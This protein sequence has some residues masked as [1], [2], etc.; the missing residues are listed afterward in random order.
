MP[1]AEFSSH[2][3]Q[4]RS[5]GG[6]PVVPAVSAAGFAAPSSL[7]VIPSSTLWNFT[8]VTALLEP[9]TMAGRWNAGPDGSWVVRNEPSALKTFT[10]PG[11]SDRC[12]RR[13]PPEYPSMER[14]L[15]ATGIPWVT[16]VGTSSTA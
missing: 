4:G 2:A 13:G 3:A 1:I 12:N 6:P 7:V 9:L 11:L 15:T 5:T 10:T 14:Q 8:S 16:W